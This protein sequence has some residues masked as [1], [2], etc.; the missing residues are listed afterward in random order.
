MRNKLDGVLAETIDK[1]WES[2][3]MIGISKTLSQKRCLILYNKPGGKVALLGTMQDEN[4]EDVIAAISV[5]VHQWQWAEAEGFTKD[6]ITT[7]KKLSDK[8]FKHVDVENLA[9]LLS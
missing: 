3:L 7:D 6:E 9:V 5:N 2:G 4:G 8:V 1:C